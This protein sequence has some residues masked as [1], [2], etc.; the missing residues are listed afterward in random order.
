MSTLSVERRGVPVPGLLATRGW[1]DPAVATAALAVS[2]GARIL[3]VCGAG[4]VAFALAAAGADVRAVDVRH[5]QLAY[6]RLALAGVRALPPHSTRSLLGLAHFGRRLWFY[7]H[8]R[9]SLDEA[10]RAF[11][12]ANE[13]ALRLGI[14]DQGSVERRV[15]T[16]RARVLPLAVPASVLAAVLAATTMDQQRRLFRE[17]WDTWRW[18]GSLK[19]AFGPLA[20]A[21]VGLNSPRL[22]G[23]RADYSAHFAQ[24]V[25]RVFDTVHVARHGGLRWA[26][27][28]ISDDQGGGPI[29]LDNTRYEPLRAAAAAITFVH[30]RL[31]DALRDPP[32]GGWNGYFL[33]DALDELAPGTA[34][35]VLEQ[36]VRSAAPGARVVT[37]RLGGSYDR[38]AALARHLVRD[39]EAS[40]LACA[41]EPIPAW[42]GVDVETVVRPS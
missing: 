18:H 33:A 42:S 1:F 31:L 13:G 23:V 30:E 32:E 39:E 12:D 8:V 17:R 15:A 6:A 37:W 21:S 10:S 11:W 34:S 4:E 2:P 24:R 29:W 16:L 36:V 5:A 7:H 28:G 41:G 19:M 9:A 25:R 38:P 20:L 3:A 22:A 14:I 35:E 40:A 26:L 27:A